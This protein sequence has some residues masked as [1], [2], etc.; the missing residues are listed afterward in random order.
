MKIFISHS[1]KDANIA[2]KLAR[3]FERMSIGVQVFC[4]SEVGT[5]QTGQDFVKGI[6][7]ALTEC[8]AFIPL[9]S[10]NYYNS[11]FCMLELGFAYAVLAQNTDVR[12]ADSYIFPVAIPPVTQAEALKGTPLSH[13]QVS[14]IHE[15]SGVWE[16]LEAVL[17]ELRS[18]KN[19]DIVKFADEIKKDLIRVDDIDSRAMHLACKGLNAS[20]EDSSYINYSEDPT[21]EGI[22]I[23]FNGK[24]FGDDKEYPDFLSF[25]YKFVDKIDLYEP[26]VFFEHSYLKA[27]LNNETDSL[28]KINVEIRYSDIN[29]LLARKSFE[30]GIG[31]NEV[32]IP[33]REIRKEAAKQVSEIC[34][35]ITPS[36]YIKNEGQFR[37]HELGICLDT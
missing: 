7:N 34:F 1:S 14:F 31:E 17:P 5:I 16:L 6:T 36:A 32:R 8:D 28:A 27:Y 9:L 29:A 26:A 11:R 24:P 25:V 33:L 18:G 15:A 3:F 35:V 30:L 12:N 2:I 19:K 23:V 21:S 4:S 37:I 10:V 20:G 13:L 22:Q